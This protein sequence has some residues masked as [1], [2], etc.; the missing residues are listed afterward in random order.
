MTWEVFYFVCFLVG[1]LFSLLTFVGGASHLHMPKGLHFHGFHGHG[2]GHAQG[3]GHDNG[4]AS[5]FNFGTITAFLAWFGGTGYLLTRYSTL[6]ALLALGLSV[7]SGLAGAAIVFW[8]V[9]KFLLGNDRDLDPA[10]YNM[11]G[12]LGRVISTVRVGGTGEMM[13]SREGARRC[14]AIRSEQSRMIPKDIEVV[15]MRYEKGI[16]YVRPWDELSNLADAGSE[17][18]SVGNS[19]TSSFKENSHGELS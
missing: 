2:V 6:M 17:S 14:V 3:V 7:V 12:V 15:V 5:W 13:F 18:E 19:P 8:F 11:I 9:F 4:P 10:D 16:A 1:F